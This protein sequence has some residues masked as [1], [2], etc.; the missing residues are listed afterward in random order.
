MA[1]YRDK[2]RLKR[3]RC[4]KDVLTSLEEHLCLLGYPEDVIEMGLEF[5]VSSWEK[6]VSWYA[7]QDE[8]NSKEFGLTE[9]EF[10]LDVWCRT[11]LHTVLQ[12]ARD[13]EKKQYQKR[14]DKADRKFREVTMRKDS[15]VYDF[16][17]ELEPEIHWWLYRIPMDGLL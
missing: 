2:M 15:P 5:F 16:L 9:M 13:Q 12:H 4:R 3:Q 10:G 11:E 7:D 17:S 14:I 8:K 1:R 6:S